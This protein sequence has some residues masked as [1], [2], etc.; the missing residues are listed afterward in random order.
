MTVGRTVTVLMCHS[1][2]LAILLLATIGLVGP[3]RQIALHVVLRRS[4]RTIDL[5]EQTVVRVLA[6]GGTA[7]SFR[8]ILVGFG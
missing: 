6:R 5:P 7:R 3:D 8:A 1:V 2:G 4:E